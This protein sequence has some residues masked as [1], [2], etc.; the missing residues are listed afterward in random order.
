MPV[1]QP[2]TPPPTILQ[3]ASLPCVNSCTRVT[4]YV[5]STRT[6]C[7]IVPCMTLAG[8]GGACCALRNIFTRVPRSCVL[9]SKPAEIASRRGNTMMSTPVLL[10]M[11]SWLCLGVKVTVTIPT[12]PSVHVLLVALLLLYRAP[13]SKTTTPSSEH[14]GTF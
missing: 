5:Y 14:F 11:A 6:R 3:V 9:D 4:V 7:H 2:F 13:V 1:N 12:R 8:V 10:C